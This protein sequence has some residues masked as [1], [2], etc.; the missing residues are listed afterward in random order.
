NIG[1]SD[2]RTVK[3]H[4]R[5]DSSWIDKRL[6][7]KRVY[8]TH[9]LYKGS[10]DFSELEFV[11]NYENSEGSFWDNNNGRNYKVAGFG[12]GEVGGNTGLLEGKTLRQAFYKFG[13]ILPYYGIEGR[14]YLKNLG[15]KKHAGFRVSIDGGVN[16]QDI[17]AI[18]DSNLSGGIE[19][20]R[21]MSV[22]ISIGEGKSPHFLFAVYY[23][24]CETGRTYWD[25]N[26]GENYLLKKVLDAEVQ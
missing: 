14:L 17:S 1:T 15:Y 4:Y 16:W 3:I 12:R 2:E 21:V 7:L 23:I 6:D 10:V 5:K 11:V 22:F 9:S 19:I 25:N 26:F 13:H 18:Y 8:P 20:W 24:D